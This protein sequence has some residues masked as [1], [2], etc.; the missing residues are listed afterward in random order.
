M[1]LLKQITSIVFSS[2]LH[3]L[4]AITSDVVSRAIIIMKAIP[5]P[6]FVLL[7]KVGSQR[8]FKIMFAG[9]HQPIWLK[10]KSS[11]LEGTQVLGRAA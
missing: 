11:D 6:I 8:P 5:N 9:N 2:A 4:F 7:W 3:A 10:M 1:A